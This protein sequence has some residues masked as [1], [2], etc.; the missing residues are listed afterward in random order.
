MDKLKIHSPDLSRDN[1]AKIRELFPG[2]VTEVHDSATQV[3][4]LAIDFDLL[5]QELS[6][7]IVSSHGFVTLP[8]KKT[9]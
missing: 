5:R 7:H 8:K 1:I 6:D 2:C 3:P 4:R 9:G